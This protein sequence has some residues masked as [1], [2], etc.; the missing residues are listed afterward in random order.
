[1]AAWQELNA[2]DK[3]DVSGIP[4]TIEVD[5]QEDLVGCCSPGDVVTVL[6]LAKVA[7]MEGRQG[8]TSTLLTLI[9]S[10]RHR[11]GRRGPS[12]SYPTGIWPLEVD[13]IHA[14]SFSLFRGV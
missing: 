11:A 9:L 13:G 10:T 7:S 1:M 3:D 6:G 8:E 12:S 5:L 4:R 2:V 14:F